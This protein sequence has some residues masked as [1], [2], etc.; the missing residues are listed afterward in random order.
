MRAPL[1]WWFFA[2]LSA[3]VSSATAILAKLGVAGVPS[4]VAVAVR[5]TVILAFAWGIELATAG[6]AAGLPATLPSLSFLTTTT[7]MM[8]MMMEAGTAA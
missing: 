5:T 8:M 2:V 6:P 1:P 7:T 4:N 3:V